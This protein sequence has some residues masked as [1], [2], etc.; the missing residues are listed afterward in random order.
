MCIHGISIVIL[1]LLL[2]SCQWYKQELFGENLNWK[3]ATIRCLEGMFLSND[4]CGEDQPTVGRWSRVYKE[5]SGGSQEEQ[6]SKQ[7]FSV[8]FA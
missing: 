1:F 4:W 2:F 5:A 3:G 6:S 7:H 8:D